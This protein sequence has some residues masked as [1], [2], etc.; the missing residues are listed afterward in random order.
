M[1]L[2]KTLVALI[3]GSLLTAGL[4]LA[5]EPAKKEAKAAACCAKA[6]KENKVCDHACCIKAA[7][8]GNNCETC[9]GSGKIADNKKEE[10]PKKK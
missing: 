1:K 3:V 10:A 7:K 6:T 2:K 5:G 4:L 9:S 8:E